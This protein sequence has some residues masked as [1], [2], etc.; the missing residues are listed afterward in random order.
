[1][2]LFY[3]GNIYTPGKH[4]AALAVENDRIKAIGSNEDILNLETPGCEKINLNGKCVW[5]GLTD[6]HLHFEMYSFS[7]SRVDCE[8]ST[9]EECLTRIEVAAYKVQRNQ[10][11]TGRGWN[12]NVWNGVYGTATQLDYISNGR[13]VFLSDKSLH[14]AWVN[15]QALTV[16]GID[17]K[18][19]D[20][21]GGSIQ[22]DTEGYPTGI[23]FENAVSLVEKMIPLPTD[24]ER[25]NAILAGQAELHRLGLTGIHDFDRASCFSSLQQL[26]QAGELSLRVAKSIPYEDL[27]HALSIGLRTGFGDDTLF[28]GSAKMFADGALGPQTAAMLEPYENKPSDRGTLLL[29]ADE[30]LETGMRATSNGIS[31]AIHAIGDRATN[32][33]LNGFAMIREFEKQNNLPPLLHRIEHL[34]L[35]HP[36][37]LQK[38][39]ALGVIA[40]MQPIHTTSDM[41]TADKHWGKRCRYAYAFASI[42]SRNVHLIFGSDAPVES[43][44]PFWGIHAAVTRRRHNG[45]PGND[46][47]NP[48]ERI[49]LEQAIRAFTQTPALAVGKSTR[50]G[51]LKPGFLADL[52]I[53]K[54]DPFNI[55]PDNL[56]QVLPESVM[57]GGKWVYHS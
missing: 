22:R 27:D 19:P 56:Y 14:T 35:L 17:N 2:I 3:N 32:E 57:V 39:A 49:T 25:R 1:M 55:H 53:L 4:T 11:V 37:D 52:L 24:A 46:G 30:V 50:F 41:F 26:H 33:V 38:A 31:L 28:T 43:P 9:I 16:A 12:Q 21:E 48:Q 20:P 54:E 34:Q 8:T 7:L 23:L 40:S 13:P 36:D 42:L 18:T 10:W 15:T 29:T 51:Q 45:E 47:W 44:N 6:S 5:P